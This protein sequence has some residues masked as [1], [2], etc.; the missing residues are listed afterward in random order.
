MRLENAELVRRSDLV[1]AGVVQ[2][3]HAAQGPQTA[4]VEVQCVLKGDRAPRQA[5]RVS[6]SPRMAESPEFTVGERVLLFL[7]GIGPDLFQLVGGV[8]GK[9][10]L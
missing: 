8:Q 5:V 3:I 2:E 9:F 7:H 1:I 10:S 6:F 4:V